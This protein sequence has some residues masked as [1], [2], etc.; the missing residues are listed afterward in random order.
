M[1]ESQKEIK[2]TKEEVSPAEALKKAAQEAVDAEKKEN[3]TSE[4][5]KE[6]SVE[7]VNGSVLQQ[8]QEAQDKAAEHYELYVRAA[9]ELENT[10]RRCE[11]DVRKARLFG[12]ESFAKNL[13]PVLDSFE[14]ALEATKDADPAIKDGLT[15]T[16]KQLS[17]AL[18]V[19]GM[20]CVDPV[21][22]PFNPEVAQAIVMV[23]SD[24]QH[25]TGTV[26]T[27]L[28][29]GWKLNERILRPAMVSVA[30]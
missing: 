19:S 1:S 17:H 13:L 14:K 18:E 6:S 29:K 26:V 11:E 24:D 16:Y 12:I 28:Q 21:G 30:K 4:I 22:E 27:V 3:G 15:I 25:A 8:L 10:R 9:A 7:D 5:Q 20:V 2:E 23:P